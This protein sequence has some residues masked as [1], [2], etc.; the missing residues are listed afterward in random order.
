MSINDLMK[1]FTLLRDTKSTRFPHG[2][3]YELEK[4]LRGLIT[5]TE[6]R[7]EYR[8]AQVKGTFAAFYNALIEPSFKKRMEKD[9]RVE[10]LILIFVSNA[11][12]QL[13]LGKPAGDDG[14]KLMLD[15]HI[16][17]FV[18]LI[19]LILK[20]NGWSRDKPELASRLTTL[21]SKLLVHDQDLAETT[22]KGTTVEV[23][24]PLSY[25]VKDMPLVQ[26]VGRI[27]DVPHLQIQADIDKNK[28]IWT[29]KAALQDLKTYQTHLNLNTR[30]TLQ[31]EDFETEEAYEAW[32]KSEAPDLS[33]M[34]LAIMQ[35]SPDLTKTMGSMPQYNPAANGG[36]PIS[37]P[38]EATRKP[39]LTSANISSYVID[40]PLDVS[41]LNLGDEAS[42]QLGE[43]ENIFTFMPVDTRSFYRSVVAQALMHDLRDESLRPSEAT[44]DMQ[45]VKL[46]S[47]QT[48]ELLNEIAVRWRIPP[49]SR[50]VLFLDVIREK[51]VDREIELRTLDDA[52][53]FVK[54]PPPVPN[55]RSSVLNLETIA[56]T[57][58]DDRS[59]WTSADVVL[60]QRLLSALSEALLREL[61]EV[62]MRCYDVHSG[63]LGPV[64]F[65][66]DHHVR[67]DPSFVGGNEELDMFRESVEV[68][69]T[70]KAK[71]IYQSFLDKQIP[72]NSESWEF[73]HVIELGKEIRK[74][75][76]RVQKRYKKNPEIMG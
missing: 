45:A 65:V 72:E 59:K 18:R 19:S 50:V 57:V 76:Q 6:K 41:G 69:L 24:I 14:W 61:Y 74:T 38:I 62:M 29:E 56:Q 11:T 42:D 5:G 28:H 17:L 35:S 48:A 36:T 52:F 31:L 27:F 1:D 55:K 26:H 47:K 67:G 23:V 13:Q 70:E 49:A 25:D 63:Q 2:F 4:R 32:K 71:E 21:E 54:E 46:F 66:M 68:G 39:S 75:A 34:M 73:Y 8:D 10:D 51:F 43:T 20:D 9:R 44:A 33:Q 40:Q 60:M 7:Q 30:R 22:Q 64:M 12:K 58:F 53:T 37:S 16:A 15:R 3:I